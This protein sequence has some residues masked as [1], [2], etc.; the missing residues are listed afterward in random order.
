M[1]KFRKEEKV[2]LKANKVNYSLLRAI[3]KGVITDEI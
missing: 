3:L 2:T 1:F